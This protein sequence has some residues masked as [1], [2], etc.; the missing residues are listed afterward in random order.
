MVMFFILE[1]K[2]ELTYEINHKNN[3]RAIK[4]E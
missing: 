2:F 4:T 1:K 3:Q